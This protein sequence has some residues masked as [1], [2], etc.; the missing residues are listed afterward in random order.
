MTTI[1][2]INAKLIDLNDAIAR[3]EDAEDLR[4][5][6]TAQVKLYNKEQL[7]AHIQS[8]KG[9]NLSPVEV[10]ARYIQQQYYSGLR[11]TVD[12]DTLEWVVSPAEFRCSMMQFEALAY[13]K[14]ADRISANGGWYKHLAAFLDNV[15]LFRI[16][17]DSHI[18]RT[19][20]KGDAFTSPVDLL[21]YKEEHGFTCKEAVPSKREL[22]D[23]LTRVFEAVLPEGMTDKD[24][25]PLV[26]VK[27]DLT[28]IID[29]TAKTVVKKDFGG[30]QQSRT[31]A[32]EK[33]LFKALEKRYTREAYSF[34]TTVDKASPAKKSESEK[35]AAK[36][37]AGAPDNAM[38]K[39]G[40]VTVKSDS[41]PK[42]A[43]QV[44]KSTRKT[45]KKS[46]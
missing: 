24:G 22:M 9:E 5:D 20:S 16:G 34:Q 32:M 29:D 7:K 28:F 33:T 10:M 18:V 8:V 15:A 42:A 12:R 13:S 11:L 35:E 44:K 21:K 4:A 27:A 30:W 36:E 26:P 2:I 39:A 6:L 1:D 37:N 25:N 45:E 40:P 17:G 46:A 19:T 38:P 41:E 23:E 3:G 31:A 14:K 43:K